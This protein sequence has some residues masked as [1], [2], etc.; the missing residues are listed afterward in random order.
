MA[1]FPHR[2]RQQVEAFA[3][4]LGLVAKPAPDGSYGFIF[5]KSG[6]LS[7]VASQDEARVVVCLVRP[8][9]QVNLSTPI[10]FFRLAGLDPATSNFVHA[11]ISAD[12]NCVLAISLE[13]SRFDMQ[14]IFETLSRLTDLYDSLA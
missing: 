14:S 13:E 5:A 10:R 9:S 3:E 12:N 1:Q 7:F 2:A 4:N 11:G 8:S 6:L